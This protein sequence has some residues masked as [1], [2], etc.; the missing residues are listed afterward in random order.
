[1]Y[2]D[3]TG[4]SSNARRVEDLDMPNFGGLYHGRVKVSGLRSPDFELWRTGEA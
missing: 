3:E 4:N 2:L 1:M